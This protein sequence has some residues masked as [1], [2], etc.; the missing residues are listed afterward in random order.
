M[1]EILCP[2]IGQFVVVYFE[3]ILVYN[4]TRDS[5]LQ[6]LQQVFEVLRQEKLYAHPKKCS[7]LTSEV[8]FLSFVISEQGV[9]EDPEKVY[10]IV[11][12]PQPGSMHDIHSFIGLAT[13]NRCFIRDFSSITSPLTDCLKKETFLWIEQ[14]NR[15]SIG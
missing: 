4:G 10:A 6:Y 3:D 12:W 11:T 9:S 15:P 13:F 5:H 1:N 14:L 8:T 7:F 2:F